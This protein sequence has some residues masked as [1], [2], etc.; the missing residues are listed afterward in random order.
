MSLFKRLFKSRASDAETHF[1]Q[2]RAYMKQKCWDE[3]V[4]E[5][6]AALRINPEYTLAH[7]S[8]G[9]VYGKQG[10]LDEAVRKFQD[11]LR[12]NPDMARAH[13]NLG[14]TYEK[15]GHLDDAI[16]EAEC[17]LQLGY[18][19]ARDLLSNLRQ[20]S[21]PDRAQ[22]TV[23]VANRNTVFSMMFYGLLEAGCFSI[24]AAQLA[25]SSR[26]ID[27]GRGLDASSVL[28]NPKDQQVM[29]AINDILDSY[30]LFPSLS[31]GQL[32]EAEFTKSLHAFKA[33]LKKIGQIA[34]G[35]EKTCTD[36]I[37]QPMCARFNWP[38]DL[39]RADVGEGKGLR[40]VSKKQLYDDNGIHLG[41]EYY[42]ESDV[43]ATKCEQPNSGHAA[44]DEQA[45]LHNTQELASNC[46]TEVQSDVSTQRPQGKITILGKDYPLYMSPI[47]MD[48]QPVQIGASLKYAFFECSMLHQRDGRQDQVCGAK[49]GIIADF[50]PSAWMC[51]VCNGLMVL[52]TLSGSDKYKQPS[53]V[54]QITDEVGA[55]CYFAERIQEA[56]R[57]K[58][59]RWLD[60]RING[61]DVFNA[62]ICEDSLMGPMISP[63]KIGVLPLFISV[64]QLERYQAVTVPQHLSLAEAH[65]LDGVECF[66]QGHVHDAIREFQA[67]LRINPDDVEAHYNLGVVYIQ[68]GHLDDAIREFQAALRINPDFVEAHGNLGLAYGQQ[69]RS[70]DAIRE[71]QSA[72]R[73]NPD[74]VEAHYNLGLAYGQQGREDEAIREIKIAA[75]LGSQQAR[76]FLAEMGLL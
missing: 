7:F 57:A 59:L 41:I 25:T 1:K 5:F 40:F 55:F 62:S 65:L 12:I 11:T 64:E 51:P 47:V 2:G 63:G 39:I 27:S 29:R 30:P 4:R 67:A 24:S 20:S 19:P 52:D 61:Q 66:Q 17:A 8:L 3:A 46:E 70:D 36:I 13:Y 35:A 23:R 43:S 9:M 34:P 38:E 74:Y 32:N 49:L 44:R 18:E 48:G 6:Q 21:V 45:E 22:R 75:Q 69:G 33:N 53:L 26:S 73:I 10:E 56:N 76:S 31:A 15:L 16:R 37:M 58:F 68:Q 14:V 71:Y 60:K 72:L 50:I 28:S 54:M 42:F